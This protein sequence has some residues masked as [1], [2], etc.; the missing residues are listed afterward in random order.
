MMAQRAKWNERTLNHFTVFDFISF[1]NCLTIAFHQSGSLPV[2][3]NSV[4][5]KLRELSGFKEKRHV[6]HDVAIA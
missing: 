1:C 4:V 3:D 2:N 5:E 6:Q